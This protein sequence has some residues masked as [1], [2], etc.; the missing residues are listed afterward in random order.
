MK[1]G[2]DG[3]PEDLLKDE[4]P[5]GGENEEAKS[6]EKPTFKSRLESFW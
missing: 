1:M 6:E 5:N 3:K 4:Q 2:I